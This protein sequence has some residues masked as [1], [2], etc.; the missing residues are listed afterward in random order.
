MLRE[1]RRWAEGGDTLSIYGV[2]F[3]DGASVTIGGLGASSVQLVD[4]RRINCKSPPH[5]AGKV[6]VCVLNPDGTND[7]LDNGFEYSDKPVQPNIWA[8][9]EKPTW[10][11]LY[12]GQGASSALFARVFID[13]ITQYPGCHQDVLAQLGW[14]PEGSSPSDEPVTWTWTDASC[15]GECSNCGE[16]DE[17]RAWLPA[18]DPGEYSYAFRFRLKDGPWAYADLW[19]GSLDGFQVKET[20]Y[21][22]VLDSDVDV[23]L[24]GLD[25]DGASIEGGERI[26]LFGQGLG[27]RCE[28]SIDDQILESEFIGAQEIDFYTPAHEPGLASLTMVQ[29][30]PG[31]FQLTLPNA[32]AFVR[33]HAPVVDGVLD[34]D[35][36]EPYLLA[37]SGLVGDWGPNRLDAVYASFDDMHLYLAAHAWVDPDSSNAVVIYLDVDY[38]AG[39]GIRD[40]DQLTDNTG[41]EGTAGLDSA[42]SARFKV[43]DPGFGAEFALGTVG[44][45]QVDESED[46]ANVRNL[47]GL[48]DI[49]D[50]GNFRWLPVIIK[51]SDLATGDGMLEVAIPWESLLGN[52]RPM[53]DMH[54]GFFARIVNSDGEYQCSCGLPD[55]NPQSPLEV[56]QVLT[57]DVQ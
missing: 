41:Y 33:R 16:A 6:S 4:S 19:P 42:I 21:L 54:L 14:G 29:Q 49:S 1:E 47:A 44:M 5:P 50:T 31:M 3:A 36:P 48:R 25:P 35:W 26:S 9:L 45:A 39:S 17:Y 12:Q 27:P 24:S 20:G 7:C 56:T 22:R 38:G 57:L 32:V 8:F 46:D 40:G 23:F 53:E 11:M 34:V 30:E 55:P 2:R 37:S 10:M 13:G 15:H 18:L 52:T 43:V 28:L 51:T